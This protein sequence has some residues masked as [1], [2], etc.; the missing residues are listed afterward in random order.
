[1]KQEGCEIDVHMIFFIRIFISAEDFAF[2]VSV[3]LFYW[4]T[5]FSVSHFHIQLADI[6]HFLLSFFFYRRTH[7][8][9]LLIWHCSVFL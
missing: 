9:I 5:S 6:L 8:W 4:E 2:V 1:V 3:S 7:F